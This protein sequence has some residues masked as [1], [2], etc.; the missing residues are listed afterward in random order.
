MGNHDCRAIG[1]VDDHERTDEVN[2][3]GEFNASQAGENSQSNV[4]EHTIV[5]KILTDLIFRRNLRRRTTLPGPTVESAKQ[6]QAELHFIERNKAPPS[7]FFDLLVLL[8][9]CL[10]QIIFYQRCKAGRRPFFYLLVRPSPG[11]RQ[12]RD[13]GRAARRQRQPD[14]GALPGGGTKAHAE[15]YDGAGA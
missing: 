15:M 13:T 6:I 12:V 4:P 5:S 2:L 10:S 7:P 14:F 11:A 1:R 3:Q 9:I 8:P